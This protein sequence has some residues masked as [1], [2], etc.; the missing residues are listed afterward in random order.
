M[1]ITFKDVQNNRSLLNIGRPV[2]GDFDCGDDADDARMMIMMMMPSTMVLPVFNVDWPASVV[3]LILLPHLVSEDQEREINDKLLS[4]LVQIQETV[5]CQL[6]L[7]HS[8]CHS[9][10]EE[11]FTLKEEGLKRALLKSY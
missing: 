7:D 1:K 11:I 4:D 2:I 8:S 6:C 10:S 9:Q 5:G 3:A